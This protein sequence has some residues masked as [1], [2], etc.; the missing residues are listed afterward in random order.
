M[1]KRVR[2]GGHDGSV[3][4][5][6]ITGDKEVDLLV[7]KARGLAHTALQAGLQAGKSL[8]AGTHDL[9]LKVFGIAPLLADE[10]VEQTDLLLQQQ[11]HFPVVGNGFDKLMR[12]AM[13]VVV[14]VHLQGIEFRIRGGH[15]GLRHTAT[16]DGIFQFKA[17]FLYMQIMVLQLA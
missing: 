4:P 17:P 7:G 12:T 13:D 14:G 9:M 11:D 15:I 2:Q 16:V 8:L 3:D 6:V 10:T 1:H 5:Y